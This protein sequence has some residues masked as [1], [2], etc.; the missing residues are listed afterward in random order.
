MTKIK[1]IIASYLGVD[2]GTINDTTN[3]VDDLG[4][5]ESAI[6]EI[7]MAI[8]DEFD[9][10]ISNEEFGKLKTITDFTK[11]VIGENKDES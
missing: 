5:D 7:I 1:E 10:T 11:Y 4:A 2:V 9:I 6:I 8:E 3:I